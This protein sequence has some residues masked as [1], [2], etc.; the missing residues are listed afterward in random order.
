MDERQCVSKT[1]KTIGSKWT[2]F[3]LHELCEGTKRF[4][5][6]E[7]SLKGISPKTLSQRLKDLEKSGVVKKTVY[8]VVPLRVEY[9]LTEK[10]R[11]LREVIDKMIEW[12]S[13]GGA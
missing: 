9:E 2:V 3:I 5:E 1:I 6:L 13:R 10:G 7:R 8:P 11:S 12:G 4:G